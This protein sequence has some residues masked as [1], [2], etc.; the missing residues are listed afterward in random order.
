[1]LTSPLHSTIESE[2]SS[3]VCFFGPPEEDG[4]LFGVV[5]LEAMKA[6]KVGEL[7]QGAT[8]WEE[9]DQ[10]HVRR[11][12]GVMQLQKWKMQHKCLLSS[13]ILLTRGCVHGRTTHVQTHWHNYHLHPF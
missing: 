12:G 8:L 3:L 2:L 6:S 5:V 9:R 13:C 7:E 4:V 11:S 1:M 10:P